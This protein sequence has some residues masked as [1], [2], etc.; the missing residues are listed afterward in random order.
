MENNTDNPTLILASSS[1]YRQVLVQRLSTKFRCESAE[2]DETPKPGESAR[3]LVERLAETKARAVAA[4]HLGPGQSGLVIGSDQAAVMDSRVIGKPET[5]TNAVE[6]L[7]Q[8]SGKKLTFL[9][10][11]CVLD[12]R[13]AT[14]AVCSVPCGVRFRVLDDK[15]IHDYLTREPAFDCA[16]AFKSEGLGIALLEHM[17]TSDPT[18]LIGLPLIS[19]TRML[20]AAGYDVISDTFLS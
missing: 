17:E 7:R 13:D 9:T 2:I 16:G 19:L 4:R 12:N 6:Q 1:R 15:Q 20:S 18:S 8:A 5:Y 3:D 11:L 14:A 10:G